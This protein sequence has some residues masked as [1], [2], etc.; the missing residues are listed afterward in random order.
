MKNKL[1]LLL[2][3]ECNRNCKG[4][5]N[6]DWNLKSLPIETDFHGYS[7]ILLT[8]GEPMLNP[9]LIIN[10]VKSIRDQNTAAKIY[11]YTAKVD[12]W[13][14]LLSVLHYVDGI[15]VTLHRQSDVP[16]FLYL[17]S[18]LYKKNFI[19]SFRVNIFRRVDANISIIKQHWKVKDN[20]EWVKNCPLPKDEVFKR[21]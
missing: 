13:Q 18:L 21:L 2:F 11:L 12:N 1:R 9:V 15:T 5:C 6:R 20:M 10:T 7:E 19:G 16:P 4:C 14:A 17:D 8:G 3:E